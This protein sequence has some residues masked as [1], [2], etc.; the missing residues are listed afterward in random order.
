MEY[1]LFL[2]QF[3]FRYEVYS[4]G[5][6]RPFGDWHTHMVCLQ[7]GVEIPIHHLYR[8]RFRKM[9]SVEENRTM[10]R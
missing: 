4:T 2:L 9:C 3:L 8:S 1:D 5:N 6:R 10:G 7:G